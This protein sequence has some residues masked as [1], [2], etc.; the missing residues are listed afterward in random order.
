MKTSGSFTKENAPNKGLFG[1]KHPSWRGGIKKDQ[2]EYLRRVR[3]SALEALG[4]KCVNCGFDD[5]R[6]LQIDH[7]NGNGS[8]ERKTRSYKGN[9]H[10]NVLRS[11]L[12]NEGKYQLLCANCNWIKRFEQ[13][14]AL[15]RPKI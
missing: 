5:F 15:G 12:K 9:F 4:N 13:K 7:V 14:E 8:N 10:L 2:K 6:A 1:E 11:F 3:N